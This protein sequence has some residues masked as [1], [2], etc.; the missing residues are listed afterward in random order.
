V[1]RL[2][3]RA[4]KR[5]AFYFRLSPELVFYAVVDLSAQG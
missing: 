3:E 1:L 4:G 2:A 5:T